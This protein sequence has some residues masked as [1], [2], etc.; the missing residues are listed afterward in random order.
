MH[1][2]GKFKRQQQD[3]YHRTVQG[4]VTTVVTLNSMMSRWVAKWLVQQLW[5]G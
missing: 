4:S 3:P 5:T 2:Y 1:I